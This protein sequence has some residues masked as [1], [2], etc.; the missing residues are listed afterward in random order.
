MKYDAESQRVITTDQLH[1]LEKLL[2]MLKGIFNIISKTYSYAPIS[3]TINPLI[4]DF[5]CLFTEIERGHPKGSST[6]DI[7]ALQSRSQRS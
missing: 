5:D 3:A 7:V 6:H 1:R 4:E 2:G